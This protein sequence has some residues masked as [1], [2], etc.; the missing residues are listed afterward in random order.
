MGDITGVMGGC[1][2]GR[3]RRRGMCRCEFVVIRG[4][5]IELKVI[6]S[7]SSRD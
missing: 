3:K 2:G 5:Y 4:W 6:A 1:G 7:K